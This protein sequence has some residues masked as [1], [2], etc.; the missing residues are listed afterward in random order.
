MARLKILQEDTNYFFP[1]YFD[2]PNDTDE[3]LAEFGYQFK[4]VRLQLPRTTRPLEGLPE[5]GSYTLPDDLED[6]MRILVGIL[7]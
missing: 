4:K 7:E 6:L 5:L 3:I 1:A 2:L